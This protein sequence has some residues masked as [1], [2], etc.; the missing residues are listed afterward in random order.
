MMKITTTTISSAGLIEA[1]SAKEENWS[2]MCLKAGIGNDGILDD[3][4]ETTEIDAIC[5]AYCR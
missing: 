5:E 3:A 2:Y 1:L 4:E